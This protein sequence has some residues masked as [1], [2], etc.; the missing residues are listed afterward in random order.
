M[1]NITE[2]AV[3]DAINELMGEKTIIMIAHRISTVQKA[4]VIYLLEKGSISSHGS[5]SDLLLNSDIFKK[6]I[7]AQE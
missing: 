4:D 2:A 7:L 5:Y 1:D 6:M 3:M